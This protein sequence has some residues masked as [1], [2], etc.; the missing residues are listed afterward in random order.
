[1][2]I[3]LIRMRTKAAR[4]PGL[5]RGFAAW[6]AFSLTL[7]FTPCCEI[8]AGTPVAPEQ[9]ASRHAPDAD[10][11][12]SH[13]T[14]GQRDICGKWLDNASPLAL[15]HDGALTPSW[16]GKA[17]VP[18]AP[19]HYAFASHDPDAVPW[20]PLHPLSPP[21]ALYLRFTRLLL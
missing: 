15:T 10:N 8:F 20:R 18:P 13:G 16:D 14:G 12:H 11:F 19:G 6:M 17:A 3:S 7:A 21:H 1:M 4:L 5:A 9:V 2:I